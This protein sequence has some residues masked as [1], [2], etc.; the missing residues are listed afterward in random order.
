[1]LRAAG[2]AAFWVL[3]ASGAPAQSSFRSFTTYVALGDS[4]GAGVANGS[5]VETHQRNSYPALIARQ[6]GVASFEQPLV[7]E[8]G[9]PPELQLLTLLPA[10]LIAPKATTPG[11]PLNLALNR[12]YNNL[13]V[14]GATVVDLLARVTDN[15]GAHDLVLRGRGTALEQALGLRPSVITLW[16]GSNDV[17][18]AALRGRALEGVTLTPPGVFRTAYQQIVTALKSTGAS[19]VAANLP[20]V[21]SI[22]FVTAIPR[23]V[24]HPATGQPVLLG[25]Q[26]VPLIG[27]AG[28]LA[29]GSFVTLAASSLLAQGIGIPT[30]AGGRGTPLPDE[31]VLDPAEVALI[32]ERVAVNNQ[33]IRDI[34]T[35]QQ[36][37]L[38]DM[39]AF[40]RELAT[41]G[42][43]VGGVRVSSE[44][45]TG[46]LFGYDGFHPTGLGQ[47]LLANEFIQAMNANGAQLAEVDVSA[48]LGVSR[49]SAAR[50]PA[51][52]EFSREAWESLLAFFPEVR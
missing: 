27:P 26:Q 9:I 20:D 7:S 52:I 51:R 21:T 17:L 10:P 38:V 32:R 15:G 6:A 34:C 50:S 13:S 44:F 42:R 2:L 24:T 22:A 30:S 40:L 46:G 33:A 11:R 18:G 8:P 41:S 29:A 16:I 43:S 47:A 19:I 14:G 36:I 31:V 39:A 48:F 12:P 25:G 37:P 3:N 49:A 4:L 23:V 45:L 1:V 35:A 5:L 28:P